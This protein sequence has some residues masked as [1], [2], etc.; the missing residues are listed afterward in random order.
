VFLDSAQGWLN[1]PR[2]DEEAAGLDSR[3][4]TGAGIGVR[5]Q[6]RNLWLNMSLAKPFT[7][8]DF[9]NDPQ[10]FF[11]IGYQPF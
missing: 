5:F 11:N 6:A 2:S 3:L 10:F 8:D 9:S 1:N 7:D 4:L